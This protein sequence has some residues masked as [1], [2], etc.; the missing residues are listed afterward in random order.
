MAYSVEIIS[1]AQ[2]DIR[3]LPHAVQEKLR[4][5][6]R[7]LADEPRPSGVKKLQGN[8]DLYSLRSG[9]FRI[10]YQINDGALLV[11]IVKVGNRREVYKSL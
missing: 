1:A 5:M 8:D 3:K 10:I 9:D 11:L 7:A 2:R 4:S 6:I